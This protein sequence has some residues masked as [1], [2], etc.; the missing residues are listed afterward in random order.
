MGGRERGDATWCRWGGWLGWWANVCLLAASEPVNHYG[1]RMRGPIIPR[2]LSLLSF[3]CSLS[4]SSQLSI[5]P[6]F[7]TLLSTAKLCTPL[8]SQLSLSLSLALKISLF[9]LL[10]IYIY[11]YKEKESLQAPFAFSPLTVLLCRR[12]FCIFKRAVL[13]CKSLC[14]STFTM[15][16]STLCVYR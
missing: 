10:Q 4:L 13:P 12:P 2:P 9:F 3:S 7:T 16:A 6:L 15:R 1:E 8:D 14:P 5:H 11:I